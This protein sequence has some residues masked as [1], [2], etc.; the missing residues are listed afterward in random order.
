[1][2]CQGLRM[3]GLRLGRLASSSTGCFGGVIASEINGGSARVSGSSGE[4]SSGNS[5]TTS[6]V[7]ATHTHVAKGIHGTCG[8][9]VGDRPWLHL[10]AQFLE[11]ATVSTPADSPNQMDSRRTRDALPG[12]TNR[13]PPLP[14][15]RACSTIQDHFAAQV[16]HRSPLAALRDSESA[17]PHDAHAEPICP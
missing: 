9:A 1:M 13:I 8:F 4:I 10:A 11:C 3:I 7:S 14:H 2:D 16:S 12:G 15:A 6:C 17:L 5:G